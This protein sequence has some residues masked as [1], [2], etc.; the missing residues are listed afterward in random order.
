MEPK[1]ARTAGRPRVGSRIGPFRLERFLGGGADTEVWRADGD[2]IVVALKILRNRTDLI[3]AAR[4]AHE[5]LALDVVRH[6]SVVHRFDADDREGEPWL[7]T[8][9]VEAGTL[10]QRLDDGTL[11]VREAAAVLAPV[12]GALAA[13]H[14]VGVIHRDVNPAN[15]L[16]GPDGPM[17]IDFGHAAIGERTWDGWTSTGAA[18]VARTE[19]YAAPESV[20]APALDAFGLGVT[21]L[22]TVT[23]N[24][25]L[26]SLTTRRAREAAVPIADL[27]AAC[28][29]RDPRRRPAMPSIATQLVRLAGDAVAPIQPPPVIVDLV[30]AEQLDVVAAAGRDREIDRLARSVRASFD[31][32]ELGAALLVAPAGTGK[33][34]LLD[35]VLD[36]VAIEVGAIT[37]RTRCTE[38]VGDLR[39]LRAVVEPDLDDVRIG[40]ATAT[41]LRSAIGIGGATTE[42]TTRDISEALLT[43]LRLRPTIVVVDD[44]HWAEPVL[45]NVL[46]DIVFRAGVPGALLMGARPGYLDPDDL[47]VETI[48]LGPLD[49]ES[50]R[51]AVLDLVGEEL[52]SAAISIAGGNPL[53]AR[54]A[55]RALSAGIDLAH[56][57]D[58]RSVVAAR[59][60]AADAR[61]APALALAAA[62][63]D[64]FWPEAIGDELLEQT[65]HL[66]RAG[67]ARPR[68]RSSLGAT[69][70]FE[71]SHPLLREVAY[72]RL[73]D[74]DRRVLHGRLA[75][76]LDE[77]VDVDAER[78][79]Q[80]A[81]LAFRGG[82]ESIAPLAARRAA[83]AVREALDHYAVNRAADWAELL[84]ETE[85][86]PQL[87]DVL[88][89]EV[90]NRQG[91]FTGALHLLLPH[92]DRDDDIGT[93]ALAVGTE[94]LVGSGDH[95]RAVEWGRSAGQRSRDTI[96]KVRGAR[97]LATAL[98]ETARLEEALAVLDHATD[99]ARD[100]DERVLALR[101]AADATTVAQMINQDSPG[102]LDSIRRA[103]AVLAEIIE[104]RADSA[105]LELAESW[106]TDAIA[107]EDPEL[108]ADI[109]ERSLEL[110]NA[111][112]D[113]ALAARAA[114]RLIEVG[115]DAERADAIRAALPHLHDAPV[116]ASERIMMAVLADVSVSIERGTDVGLGDRIAELVA[117]LDQV[118]DVGGPDQHLALCAYAY[119]GRASALADALE[120]FEARR[121]LPRLFAIMTRLNSAILRAAPL[122]EVRDLVPSGTTAFNNE[123]AALAF[124]AR[125]DEVGHEL[126]RERRAFL[127]STGNTHQ[128]YAPTFSGALFSALGPPDCEPDVAWLE[129]QISRPAFP[130]LWTFQRAIAALL[131]AERGAGER[132]DL[133][134]WARRLRME[135]EPDPDVAAWFDSRLDGLR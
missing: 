47:D 45:L 54:E 11:D 51:A 8:A 37:R 61:L 7:A 113:R 94:S 82:D 120:R 103:R 49:D 67:Y 64:G 91:D 125:D 63:G 73:T 95:E 39:V 134:D 13:A 20:V 78:V 34:W 85:R 10:A 129:R 106:V 83:E 24:R 107:I 116:T 133:A 27:V 23:G 69:T 114:R 90:K 31:A 21:L 6:P 22:E 88:S 3:A 57:T 5:A 53:H 2:G 43:V 119:V 36:S 16:L 28:C 75:R 132:H 70:E 44:L 81:A 12:A 127:V 76:R 79:A 55:A 30:R 128:G 87:A 131:L 112:G 93:L 18:A 108:A 56:A 58:L 38:T 105:L 42:A 98:R 80:H 71:W 14:S 135:T 104:T 26:D 40:V 89:A 86:E 46:T 84:R 62:S 41:L 102:S 52:A 19:G 118:A 1:L 130:G 68:V 60:A 9:L 124:L 117:D 4:L 109:Q 111:R 110:A 97:S 92:V 17:L 33:S 100:L 123:L 48:P 66:V 59:L 29:E 77:R 126:L 99:I 25:S 15:I 122:A 65:P 72:E 121:P 35:R 50:L 115:W 74:L 101:L 32:H 96:A